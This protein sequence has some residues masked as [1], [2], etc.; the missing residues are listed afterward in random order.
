MPNVPYN[1]RDRLVSTKVRQ[2]SP[3]S[4]VIV[5]DLA[6]YLCAASTCTGTGNCEHLQ[7]LGFSD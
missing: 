6:E 1:F 4:G 2:S 5:H 7:G 3:A